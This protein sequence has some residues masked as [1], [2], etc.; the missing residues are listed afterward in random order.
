M[1]ASNLYVG[2]DISKAKHDVAVV[3]EQQRI[4][5][6]GFVIA[7]SGCGFQQLIT[8]LEKLRQIYDASGICLGMEATGDY[9]KNL[10]TFLLRQTDWSV[11]VINPLQ[12]HHFAIS[13][14]RRAKTDPVDAADIARFMQ[15]RKPEPTSAEQFGL[16]MIRDMDKQIVSLIKQ[17]NVAMYR[18][19]LELGK[20]FPE[21]EQNTRSF[22]AQRL[23]ALLSQYPTPEII[24]QTSLQTFRELRLNGTNR[25]IAVPYLEHIKQLAT[26]SIAC[27]TG[28][29]AG[30]VVQSL[31]HQLIMIEQLI[32]QMKQQLV[33]VFEQ[34]QG[35]TCLLAT[36]PGIAPL[37]AATLEAYIGNVRRFPT[38]K[39]IIAYF[40]LNP[41]VRQS[42]TS[43]SGRSR[44]QKRGNSR[45][46]NI[47]FMN[48]LVMIRH[49]MDPIY[50]FYQKKVDEGKPKMVAIGA[51][52][53]K[54]LV[55]IYTMLKTN[56]AFN[57]NN[58]ISKNN[59]NIT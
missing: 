4:L 10:Y 22:T 38:S 13:K 16:Q 43:I 36:V 5:I 55:I 58:N 11:T 19:R 57:K 31:A 6:P 34:Q 42:G 14:L 41:T 37:T 45:V 46:R 52:M 59:E 12:T 28:P 35:G 54:L 3:N 18:L 56:S 33:Q 30:L 8:R 21:L 26:E 32:K 7:E 51:A 53:R 50:S 44:L 23:L 9:W 48:V 39:Q 29:Y 27:K 15:E 20:T 17:R 40:G 47:L 49:K 2:I 25:R 1:N 24:R